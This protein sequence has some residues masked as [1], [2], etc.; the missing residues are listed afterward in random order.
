VRSVQVIESLTCISSLVG[1][2]VARERFWW[3]ALAEEWGQERRLLEGRC[4]L[5]QAC[6]LLV[7]SGHRD[8]SGLTTGRVSVLEN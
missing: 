3:P 6:R 1:A 7:D 2:Y 4:Q 5:N 8:S